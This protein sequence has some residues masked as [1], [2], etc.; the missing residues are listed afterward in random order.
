MAAGAY[1]GPY[2]RGSRLIC[3]LASASG[4][5]CALEIVYGGHAQL[6]WETLLAKALKVTFPVRAKP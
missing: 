5:P 4:T 1:E 3:S 6:I 2:L